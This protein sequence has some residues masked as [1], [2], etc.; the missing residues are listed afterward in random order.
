MQ[1]HAHMLCELYVVVS[2][3]WILF[4]FVFDITWNMTFVNQMSVFSQTAFL[5]GHGWLMLA[6]EN[7]G[8]QYTFITTVWEKYCV[9]IQITE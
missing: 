6:K 8:W 9:C 7:A 2:N 5:W 3:N 4:C 1:Q